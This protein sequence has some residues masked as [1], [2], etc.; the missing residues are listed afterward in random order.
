MTALLRGRKIAVTRPRAQASSLAA[1]IAE[2]GGEP[3]I[4]PLLEISPAADTA[5][6][7]SAIADLDSY[8]LAVFIS[9]N[10]VA[11][12]LP[13]ILAR[14][15]WP[16][17]LQAVAIGQGS[18]AALAA[19][20]IEHTLAPSERFDSEAVL[21]LPALQRQHVAGKRVVI[22]RGNGGRELL[23]DTLRAR[24]AEVDC[25]GCYQRSAPGDAA[26]L[27]ALLHA[28]ELD[29]LTV[30]SSE[31][32]R[33]LVDLLDGAARD[34]LRHTPLFVP[35]RR[36]ADLAQELGLPRV[37]LTGPADAG[38]IAALRTHDWRAA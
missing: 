27:Q 18:V 11:F 19:Y 4:F 8:A 32:L 10:A 38:I 31:G 1:L 2:Q 25:V 28:G 16:A 34:A 14:R 12:S 24:A 26:P 3:V 21:E 20:G 7:L 35:H 33:N 9:P 22:F 15:K 36:I 29:A 37:I 17:G 13:I 23:A 6:L 5:P 30:S